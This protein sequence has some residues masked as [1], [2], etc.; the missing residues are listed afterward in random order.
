M[1]KRILAL[2][3]AFIISINFIGSTSITAYA[4]EYSGGGIS[5]PA[6]KTSLNMFN[7]WSLADKAMYFK[8]NLLSIAG[9][10]VGIVFN[11][12]N[13][14]YSY[15]SDQ[16]QQLAYD[17]HL[18][19]E[20]EDYWD[21]VANCLSV[22]DNGEL[23][24][25]DELSDLIYQA[26]NVYIQ[27]KTG[28]FLG[29]TFQIAD[30]YS[31]FHTKS[32][33]S[34]VSDIIK[35]LDADQFG[36]LSVFTSGNGLYLSDSEG[37]AT[38]HRCLA[39]LTVIQSDGFVKNSSYSGAVNMY[40]NWA[41]ASF[42]TDNYKQVYIFDYDGNELSD[43][44]GNDDSYS[45]FNSSAKLFHTTAMVDANSVCQC[46][47]I[48]PNTSFIVASD[49]REVRIYN[50]YEEYKAYTVGQRSYY[51]TDKFLDY[52]INGDNSCI[53]SESD[54]SNGSVYGDVYNYII[55][56]YDNPD[57]L[58]EDEL[59]D[60]LDDYFNNSGGGSGSSGN[61]SGG[62]SGSS[63]SGFLGFLDG[64]GSLGDAI[65][66]ILGKLIEYIGKAIDLIVNG[67]TDIID[68][69]PK[70]VTNLIAAMFPFL[71]EE[72]FTAIELALILGVV[73]IV[74]KIFK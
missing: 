28:Y 29:R 24:V 71:P 15:I 30:A 43:V 26:S 41:D 22:N 6:D 50:N 36:V 10:A 3:G 37:V 47:S 11:P 20:S 38:F 27:E 17:C 31:I 46:S 40:Y 60:I 51:V 32:Q 64:L 54:L 68:K 48:T 59:R 5:R 52:D 39:V 55:N 62:N 25:N 65:L 66:G 14:D 69:I 2:I 45:A 7:E 67:L 49:K 21:W 9:G 63:G 1:R 19:T 35:N 33:Y 53:L 12:M 56:N 13:W 44:Y 74:I 34:A 70:N 73:C 8:D 18:I 42:A 61:D 58:T 16:L 57:G 23:V 4:T 72:F